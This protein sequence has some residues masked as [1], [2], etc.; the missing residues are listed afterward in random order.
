MS[1]TGGRIVDGDVGAEHM[2][3]VA[4]DHERRALVHADPQ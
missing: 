4:G 3:E 1:V 2:G